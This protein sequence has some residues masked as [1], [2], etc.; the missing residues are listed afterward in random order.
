MDSSS[1]T[2]VIDVSNLAKSYGPVRAVQGVTFQVAAGEIVGFLGP[3]GAGKTTTMRMLT[4]FLPATEGTVKIAGYDVF[5]Q[6]M[7]A[8]RHIGYLPETPPVYPELTI[9]EYLGFVAELKGV[10]RK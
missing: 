5:E 6:A 1:S 3:N 8:R 7:E 2:P 10:A 9:L 4:G